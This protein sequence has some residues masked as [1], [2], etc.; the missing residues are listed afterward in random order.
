MLHDNV[1]GLLDVWDQNVSVLD[2]NAELS[3]DG[4]V[5]LNGGFDVNVSA[6]ISPVGH[7]TYGDALLL[8]ASLRSICPGQIC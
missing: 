3:F 4:L 6:L 5:D 8:N 7:E 2:V 1:E